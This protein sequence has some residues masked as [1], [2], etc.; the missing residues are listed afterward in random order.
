MF[1]NDR[2]IIRKSHTITFIAINSGFQLPKSYMFHIFYGVNSQLRSLCFKKQISMTLNCQDITC[3]LI[4]TNFHLKRSMPYL[5]KFRSTSAVRSRYPCQS[6]DLGSSMYD[7]NP[8]KR[9]RNIHIEQLQWRHM[10]RAWRSVISHICLWSLFTA[11]ITLAT[12]VLWTAINE[13]IR[14]YIRAKVIRVIRTGVKR[15][16][17]QLFCRSLDVDFDFP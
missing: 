8:L 9:N 7:I 3:S 14:C 15:W 2:W 11:C 13:S 10:R 16:C 4:Y 12:T 6:Y 1:R 5:I 17:N